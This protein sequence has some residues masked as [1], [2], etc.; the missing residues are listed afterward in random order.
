[1]SFIYGL[2]KKKKVFKRLDKKKKKNWKF[3]MYFNALFTVSVA[4]N[5]YKGNNYL[6]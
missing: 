1:M 3:K 6:S 5:F 2:I 4:Y